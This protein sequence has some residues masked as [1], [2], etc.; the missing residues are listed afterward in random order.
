MDSKSEQRSISAKKEPN[1]G[2]SSY[3]NIHLCQHL[4]VAHIQNSS[5]YFRRKSLFWNTRFFC[6][7]NFLPFREFVADCKN[8]ACEHFLVW[9]IA[10][11]I[12]ARNAKIS[13]QKYTPKAKAP[14]LCSQKF[15]CLPCSCSCSNISGSLWCWCNENHVYRNIYHNINQHCHHLLYHRVSAESAYL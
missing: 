5:L 1:H 9:L 14:T 12:A 10:Y 11:V 4:M 3:R 15:L 7:L 6:L 13:S 8:W 2:Y